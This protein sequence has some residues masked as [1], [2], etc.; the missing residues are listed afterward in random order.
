[1]DY[2]EFITK[3]FENATP[4]RLAIE[5]NRM[6]MIRCDAGGKMLSDMAQGAILYLIKNK[7]K[8]IQREFRKYLGG[9]YE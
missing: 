3:K 6:Q 7:D 8:K 1:M 9:T 4:K 5:Y 2:A